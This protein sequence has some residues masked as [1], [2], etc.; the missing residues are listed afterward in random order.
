[1]IILQMYEKQKGNVMT[2]E[3]MLGGLHASAA[4]TTMPKIVSIKQKTSK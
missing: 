4:K 1:M 2:I 3:Q